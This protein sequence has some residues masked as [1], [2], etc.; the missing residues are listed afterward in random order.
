[1]NWCILD[2]ETTDLKQAQICQTG[3]IAPGMPGWQTLV[4]PTIPISLEAIEIHGI[5]NEAVDNAPTFDRVF[6]ELMRRIGNRDLIIYNADFDLRAI[7]NS[8]RVHGIQ[9]AFP[10]SD[11]RQ[12]RIFTNGGS[13]DCAMLWYSQ[14]VGEWNA[15]HGNYKW[16]PLIGGNHSALGDCEATLKIIEKM[17][18]EN[19]E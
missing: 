19:D 4:K 18:A 7:K 2:T 8:L 15:F 14:W 6:L 12:C 5:T 11:R 17:S 1:N 10:T 13:I 3:V 16:Q 9:L